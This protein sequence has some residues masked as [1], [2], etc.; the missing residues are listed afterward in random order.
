M[1]ANQVI[2]HSLAAA[3]RL[4]VREAGMRGG[5]ED[6]QEPLWPRRQTLVESEIVFGGEFV[7]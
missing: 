5:E 2:G 1:F 6:I 7:V 4:G 3:E